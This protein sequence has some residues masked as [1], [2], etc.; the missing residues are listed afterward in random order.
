MSRPL[1]RR[2]HSS[3]TTMSGTQSMPRGIVWRPS[4]RLTSL[5]R[6]V[7]HQL[8]DSLLLIS[9]L[10]L[11]YSFSSNNLKLCSLVRISIIQSGDDKSFGSLR[12]LEVAFSHCR[13]GCP[14]LW[15]LDIYR[16]NSRRLSLSAHRLIT[17]MDT[18]DA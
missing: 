3:S 2:H 1:P 13:Q 7:C 10:H 17:R 12:Q 16:S 15:V 9:D 14:I 11:I 18:W 4:S 5:H 6:Y 8:V